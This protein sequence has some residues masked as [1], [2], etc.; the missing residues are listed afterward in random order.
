MSIVVNTY[1]FLQRP[2]FPKTLAAMLALEQRPLSVDQLVLRKSSF[3]L[4]T[5]LTECA[6]EWPL[7]GVNYHLMLRQIAFLFETFV[8]NGAHEWTA[9]GVT[10]LVH[11]QIVF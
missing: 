8:T 10:F 4:K 2:F 5:F 1:M 11:C 7:I 3:Q 9:V 6:L